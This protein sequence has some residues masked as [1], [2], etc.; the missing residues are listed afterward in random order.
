MKRISEK[1]TWWL[2]RN[3]TI[4]AEDE[5]LYTY[6]IC[7]LLVD[8]IDTLSILVLALVFGEIAGAIAFLGSFCAMRRYC[9]GFHANTP[10][11]C[12]LTTIGTA[13]LALWLLHIVEL[14]ITMMLGVV[15]LCGLFVGKM[16]PVQAPNKDLD[17]NECVVYRRRA[18]VMWALTGCLMVM[19]LFFH[20]SG[21]ALGIVLSNVL[22]V[23][24]MGAGMIRLRKEDSV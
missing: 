2:Q 14:P 24:T 12:Y 22:C 20:L 7:Q 9:G 10:C 6:G 8:L 13:C 19:F 17:E 18:V 3:G 23:T 15:I 5:E 4:S 1:L 21:P 16:A 11:R